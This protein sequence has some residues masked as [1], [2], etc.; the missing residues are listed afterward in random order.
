MNG[1]FS[2]E[3]RQ[4]SE[5]YE[6][7][8][9]ECGENRALTLAY[10]LRIIEHAAGRHLDNFNLSY[11]ELVRHDAVFLLSGIQLE[12]FRPINAG[13]EVTLR[14]WQRKIEKVRY[15][16]DAEILGKD[17]GKRQGV[18]A[19]AGRGRLHRKTVQS[20][21]TFGAGQGAASKIQGLWRKPG[22]RGAKGR[23]HQWRACA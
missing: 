1:Y 3:N 13:E 17:G 2:N 8:P 5:H 12:F 22:S 11:D 4:Y 9:F 18:R 7:M 16:R 19:F 15:I 14:T 20:G 10:A 6:I 21:G 23:N